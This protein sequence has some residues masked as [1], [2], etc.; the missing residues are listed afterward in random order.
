[1][2][3]LDWAKTTCMMEKSAMLPFVLSMSK[4]RRKPPLRESE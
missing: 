1:L 2:L 4:G 3:S